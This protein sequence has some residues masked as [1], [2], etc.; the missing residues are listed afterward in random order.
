MSTVS[1]T[2][3]MTTTTPATEAFRGWLV[4]KSKKKRFFVVSASDSC[5][6]W[7][8]E[9]ANADAAFTVS[10]GPA[11]RQRLARGCLPL[12]PMTAVDVAMSVVTVRSPGARP[13]PFEA[14]TSQEAAAFATAV[15]SVAASSKVRQSLVKGTLLVSVAS[16]AAPPPVK[17]KPSFVT[18]RGISV[19]WAAS[20]DTQ[21]ALGELQL[22]LGTVEWTGETTLLLRGA[23]TAGVEAATAVEFC[24]ESHAVAMGWWAAFVRSIAFANEVQSNFTPSAYREVTSVKVIVDVILRGSRYSLRLPSSLTPLAILTEAVRFIQ[25]HFVQ[26]GSQ[27]LTPDLFILKACGFEL[28]FSALDQPLSSDPSFRLLLRA[29]VLPRL[30]IAYKSTIVKAG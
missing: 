9:A 19:S 13:Y 24:A 28:S 15:V 1:T 17:P 10:V 3:A 5:V 7:F 4:K 29:F 8:A 6:W 20:A 21:R 11:Q 25:A 12:C 30:C 22:A 2:T 18:L 16:P 26:V 14:A 23:A 27:Q